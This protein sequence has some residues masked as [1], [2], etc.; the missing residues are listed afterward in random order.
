MFLFQV[1]APADFGD[2][3]LVWTLTTHGKTERAYASLRS[4]YL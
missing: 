4:D 3:E 2:Q 1:R